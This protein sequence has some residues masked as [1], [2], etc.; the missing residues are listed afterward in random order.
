[1][2]VEDL[3]KGFDKLFKSMFG[4]TFLLGNSIKFRYNG[5]NETLIE[6]GGKTVINVDFIYH[7]TNSS[8]TME[9]IEEK[10]DV[11][12]ERILKYLNADSHKV[13]VKYEL[14]VDSLYISDEDDTHLNEKFYNL[15]S[16]TL[17]RPGTVMGDFTEENIIGVIDIM[18]ISWGMK[19]LE[20]NDAS[21]EFNVF[22]KSGYVTLQNGTKIDLPS[23][24]EDDYYVHQILSES[25]CLEIEEFTIPFFERVLTSNGDGDPTKNITLI[26]TL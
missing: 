26:S 8:F 2:S 15:T 9:F 10:L 6:A 13:I 5:L 17:M 18:P 7:S 25:L 19:Y 4:E 11:M 20:P 1:M 22:V 14:D 3:E 21:F 23:N 24:K 16:L 12:C